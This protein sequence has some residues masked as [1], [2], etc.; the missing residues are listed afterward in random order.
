MS[1]TYTFDVFMTLDGFASHTGDWGGYWG[2]QGPEWLAHRAQEYA[3]TERIVFGAASF[4]DSLEYLA[5]LSDEQLGDEWLVR[6]RQLP[7]TVVSSTLTGPFEWPDASVESGDA[8]DVVQRLKAASDG[9]L[10]SHGSLTLNRAVLAAG[11]IDEIEVT[12]FPV[13]SGRTGVRPAFEAVGD[14]DLELLSARTFDA[15]IQVLTYRP[16]A[17]GTA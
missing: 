3:D 4:R 10:R 1:A 15:S 13:L 2:K 9:R 6:L 17:H 7:A 5:G 14:F 11:L 16:T 8:A 12:V